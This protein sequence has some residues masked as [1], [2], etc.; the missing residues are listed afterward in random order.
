[1]MDPADAFQHPA[2]RL[3]HR[4]IPVA[5]PWPPGRPALG[6]SPGPR[7]KRRADLSARGSRLMISP[8][9]SVPRAG[10]PPGATSLVEALEGGAVLMF[11]DLDFPFSAF[12][13]RFVERPF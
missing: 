8:I 3:I 12:E 9:V 13:E 2:A 4:E 5:A 10:A 6:R 1:M 7:L 11:P